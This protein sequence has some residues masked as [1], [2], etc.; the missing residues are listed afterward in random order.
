[1]YKGPATGIFT[2]P[3][4]FS[5]QPD[6]ALQVADNVVFTSPFVLEPR[7]GVVEMVASTFGTATSRADALAYYRGN[8]SLGAAFLVAFDETSLGIKIEAA[9]FT[10]FGGTFTSPGNYRIKFEQAMKSMYFNSDSGTYVYDGVGNPRLAGNPQGLGVYATNNSENGWQPPNEAC[11]YR[12][13][14]C[15]KDAFGR[16]I[17]GPPS[18]RTI[19]VNEIKAAVGAGMSRAANVVYVNSGNNNPHYLTT[20]DVVTLSPGETDFAAGDKTVTVTSATTFYYAEAGASTTNTI[21][22]YF[23]ITRSAD[24]LLLV[25]NDAGQPVTESNFLRVYRS[26]SVPV[27]PLTGAYEPTD[28]M[29]QVYETGYLTAAEVALGYLTFND[30][31]PEGFADVPL[32]TNTNTAGG[33]L[34]ARYPPPMAEDVHFFANRMWYANTTDR[35]AL[36]FALI[37]T[38]SPDGLQIGDTITIQW[39]TGTSV[40]TAIEENTGAPG[41]GEFVVYTSGDPGLNIEKTARSLALAINTSSDS[42]VLIYVFYVSSDSGL[43]GK[44]RFVA[45]A[46]GDA[47]EFS[48]YSDR[49]TAWTPQ[50]PDHASPAFDP[51][52][53]NNN[54]HPARLYYSEFD[55]PDGVGLLQFLQVDADDDPILRIFPLHYRL[56]IFKTN[57]IY[58]CTNAE[59]FSIQKMSD[60]RLVASDSVALLDN[61]LY[62]LTDQGIVTVSDSGVQPISIP[63]DDTLTALGGPTSLTELREHTVAV[64]YRSTRQYLCWLIDKNDD[65]STFTDDNA[66]AF[67]YSTLSGGFTKYTFGVRAAVLDTDNDRLVF[68]PTDDNVLWQERKTLTDADY[69][70]SVI[71]SGSLTAVA[72]TVLTLPSVASIVAGDVITSGA[73]AY[74]I[75]SVGVAASTVTTIGATGWTAGASFEVVSAISCRVVFSEMTDGTPALTKMAQQVSLLFRKNAMQTTVA[76]FSS[77]V[78]QA[79]TTVD[80]DGDGWGSFAWGSVAWGNPPQ[81]IRRI[82]PLPVGVGDCAQLTAGFSTRQAN[83][84]FEFLGIDAISVPDGDVNRG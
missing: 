51:P 54:R 35:H 46:F 30:V 14:I 68:A 27:N 19:L 48:L 20:G 28:E 33:I 79:T 61:R 3:N 76:E 59:P 74:V 84:K 60:Y 40:F 25:P 58:F 18:G 45:R 9:P 44:M 11:A 23:E 10:T 56:I 49:G 2:S 82:Q 64:A 41:P 75:D 70:D 15:S 16:V 34:A 71:Q 42:A 17:E 62:C 66:S 72:G 6:G 73:G 29:F 37:G 8:N 38:G 81:K 21:T 4:P 83:A 63:I 57:G 65:G 78:N 53:S 69:A 26:D 13:T 5:A 24:I 36:D 39:A 32:Y 1:M 52:E 12:F 47:S 7:R 77:E 67:V 22:E 50:L 43:P 55:N 31:T 80:L